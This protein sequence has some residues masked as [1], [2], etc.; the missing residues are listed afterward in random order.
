MKITVRS[1]SVLRDHLPCGRSPAEIEV[2]E[3]ASAIDVMNQLGLPLDEPYLVMLNGELLAG[4]ARAGVSL[5]DGD[6]LGVFPPL[7]GG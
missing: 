6:T 3:G 2:A 7:K 1:A 5:K 4:E